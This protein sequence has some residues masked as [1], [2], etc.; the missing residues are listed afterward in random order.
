MA[1]IMRLA[2]RLLPAPEAPAEEIA[3]RI[4]EI[5]REISGNMCRCTGYLKIIE[6]VKAAAAEHR[7]PV[8]WPW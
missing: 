1:S 7:S 2:T 5:R 4:A 3:A 8:C 6:A